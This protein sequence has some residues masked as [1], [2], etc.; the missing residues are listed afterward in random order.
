VPAAV[1][2]LF[3][4]LQLIGAIGGAEAGFVIGKNQF[5]FGAALVAGV[6]GIVVGFAIG[7]MPSLLGWFLWDYLGITKAKTDTLRAKVKN[8]MTN[9]YYAIEGWIAELVLRGEAVE[10]FW[11]EVLSLL[12]SE[13]RRNSYGERYYGWENLNIWFPR[14]AR[15][16]NKFDPNAP[17]NVRQELLAKIEN[18]IPCADPLPRD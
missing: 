3:F 12:R 14:I 5:G 8:G 17:P 16:I 11:P 13:G 15:L 7:T 10:S 9:G 6:I 4:L 1:T 18:A 2:E